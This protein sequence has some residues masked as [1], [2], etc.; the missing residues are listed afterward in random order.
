MF[1]LRKMCLVEGQDLLTGIFTPL[2]QETKPIKNMNRYI[3]LF[4]P[5]LVIPSLIESRAQGCSDAGF[6]TVGSLKHQASDSVRGSSIQ[7]VLP[8][9]VGDEDVRVFTPGIQ[10]DRQFSGKWALQGR[11]SANYASG[12][13]GMATG[14]GD[15]YVSGIH[16]TTITP[17]WKVAWMLAAKLPLNQSTLKKEG[18]ALPMVYQSSLGTVDV[19]SGAS[20]MHRNWLLSFGWQQP[21]SRMNGNGFLPVRWDDPDAD[22]YPATNDF[23]RKG[24]VLFRLTYSGQ[25]TPGVLLQGG[26]LNIYHLG[27]DTYVD[28]NVSTGPIPIRGSKGLTLNITGSAWITISR[29]L[30]AGLVAGIPVI[31][32]KVRPDGLTRHFVVSPELRW[33]L[34]K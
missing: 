13:L 26:L 1:G 33:G 18:K 3:L 25:V 30:T 2:G 17:S 29:N 28:E 31:V 5:L 7:L 24:D 16:T 32:R 15:I 8:F 34:G 14:A 22:F 23:K 6:C 11:V 19:I 9:G 20:L 12:N 27:D 4:T 10:Y 21:L